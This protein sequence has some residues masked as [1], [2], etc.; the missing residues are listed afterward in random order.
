[1]DQ[2][3]PSRQA[4]AFALPALQ[5]DCWQSPVDALP[6][7]LFCLESLSLSPIELILFTKV[8]HIF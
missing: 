6:T 4:G 2:Q 3:S 5:R 1:M 8:I 7:P